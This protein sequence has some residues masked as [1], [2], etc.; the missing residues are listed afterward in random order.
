[1][2]FSRPTS[3]SLMRPVRRMLSFGEGP[4]VPL[5][6][7]A[8]LGPAAARFALARHPE[9]IK[10][11]AEPA[12]VH[13]P[14][15][16]IPM[17]LSRVQDECAAGVA[18][19]ST[20]HPLERWIK[21]GNTRGKHEA[22]ERRKTLVN[23]SEAWCRQSRNPAIS[24]AA[25]CIALDPDFD[26]VTQDPGVGTRIMFSQAMLDAESIDQLATFWP[27]VMT[28]ANE[29]IDVPWTHRGTST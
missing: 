27:A 28:V 6:D 22:I 1:M 14:D 11:L 19:E 9:I 25:M 8:S 20:L 10:A 29:A 16:A 24:I 17:L 5:T 4:A 21:S 15:E 12:L 13:L 3:R 23:C 18:L 7:Y 26:F 2:S